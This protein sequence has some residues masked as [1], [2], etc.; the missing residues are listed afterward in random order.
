MKKRWIRFWLAE[1]GITI[2]Y[3]LLCALAGGFLPVAGAAALLLSVYWLG[4]YNSLKYSLSGG[5][6]SMTSGILFRKRRII[7][8]SSILWEMRLTSPLF[9][10]CAMAVLHTSGGSAVIFADFSTDS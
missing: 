7:P 10:G 8:T 6:I 3:A 2:V 5:E 4:Y 1:A 9:H